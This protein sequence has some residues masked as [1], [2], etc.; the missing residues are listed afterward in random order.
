M[1]HTEKECW[2]LLLQHVDGCPTCRQH[3][4]RLPDLADRTR[5]CSVGQHLTADWDRA[6]RAEVE[7]EMAKR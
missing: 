5:L 6:E 3:R 2:R 1:K 4:N 7:Q